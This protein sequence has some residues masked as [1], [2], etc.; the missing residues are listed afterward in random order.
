MGLGLL[1][2]AAGNAQATGFTD[3]FNANSGS[4]VATFTRVL[5]GVA[6]VY[7]FTGDGD[8]GNTAW[9]ATYGLGDSASINLL[10]TPPG[11]NF[12]TTEKFTIKRQDGGRFTFTSLFV[13]NTAG[14][15]VT[16]A[17][18]RSNAPVSSAQ[19]VNTGAFATLTFAN[20]DVDEVRVT[21]TDFL[22]TNLDAFAGDTDPP[23]T[24]PDAPTIGTATAG[25]NQASVT[26]TAPVNNGGAAI[27]TYTATA[28]PGGAFGTCAGPAAC[29]ATVT[30][31]TNGTAYTFTV[32]AT[33][34]VGTSSAS[35]ASNSATPKAAQTITF[36]N[37]G[38]QNFGTSPTLTA[39]AT[40]GLTP[41]FTSSTTGVCT[42]TSGG[43]LT[44]VT[45]G[46]CTI[47]ADQAGNGSF[48]AATTVSHS[49]TVNAIL[50]G[51]PTIGTATAGDTQASVTF[52]AP[53]SSGGAAITT[54]TATAS[55]GGAFGTCAGPAACTITVTGLTNG[56][57]YTFTVT[58]T[59]STGTGSASAAS[60]AVTPKAAQ[61]ITFNNPGTQNFGTTPSLSATALS[62]LGVTFTSATTGVCTI[63]SGGALTFVTVGGCTINADQ[64]GNGSYLA[65]PQVSQSFTVAAV[66]PGAPTIGAATAGDTQAMVAFTAP[67]FTGGATITGYTVTSNPGGVTGT[68]A[69]SPVVVLGLTNGIAYTFTVT[70]TNSAGTGS[71]SA[72]SNS[73]TPK[74][75]Q[76]ITFVA[77]GA[78]N[79]GTT[80]TLSATA[81]SG[82]NPTFTSS[83]TG[84]CTITSGG[85]L[86]FITA[87]TCT[88]N[89]DQAGNGSYLA[90]P[91]VVR[92]FAVNAVVPGA[93]TIGVATAGD[94]QVSVAFTP[95]AFAGGAAI[96]GY[97]VT[98]TPGGITATGTVS[99]IVVPGLTN[100][101]AYTFTVTATNSA[102]TGAASAASN[103]VTPAVPVV[104][105]PFTPLTPPAPV[106]GVS[107][108]PSVVDMSTGSGPAMGSCTADVVR[109]A[110][111]GS[112]TYIG[113][114]ASGA[115]QILWN[116]QIISFYPLAASTSNAGTTGIR[117]QSL[118][119]LDVISSCGTLT[120]TPAVYSM[121]ELGAT[122]TGMGLTAQI[123]PQ[124]VITVVVNGTVFAVRP[125]FVVTP[126]TPGAPRLF[127]GADG[128]YRFTDSAGNTQ[129]MRPAFVDPA[130]LQTQIGL[131]GGSMNVQVDGTVFLILGGQ[132]LTLTADLTLGIIAPAHATHYQ[133]QDGPNHYVYRIL[134]QPY[135][136]YSQGATLTPR[137]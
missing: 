74:A 129:I 97:T 91:Q 119:P 108:V 37:P 29:T 90:A 100:G 133:W 116:G 52:T 38:A 137:P 56:V 9:E 115:T 48:N 98:S 6:Y 69:A 101:I 44:F 34:S 17:G 99:P 54:Y 20:L 103:S 63:T 62:G 1:F 40:S 131:L 49:F 86:T 127:V 112:A 87:G 43:T 120:V 25:N 130:A 79:F 21:S 135:A 104:A 30:G 128:L 85:A 12:G 111:G 93:P 18:Y 67:A 134:A 60:N 89:A 88:I 3:N 11:A 64:A 117:N 28:S 73:I 14:Q 35:G 81:D 124:G 102:G 78:Q 8:G 109:Q 57:S 58:A 76:T 5:G 126:G 71:A 68:G 53:A 13:N 70:A 110:L 96:T 84:V 51:A 83:T 24:V 55:P 15:T 92:S 61:T 4:N 41:T 121:N 46:T 136:N 32:T 66:V 22:N 114:T 75:S 26:F 19:S 39:T 107:G 31:L 50:P 106:P 80:P 72:A 47:D 132:N 2:M 27:T 105:T 23:L 82:L 7:T 16:V 10:S 59:N 36:N 123:N 95:P 77:P 113:Q 94:A 125:D 33:N 45:A 118:N 42:I 122:L 65:A